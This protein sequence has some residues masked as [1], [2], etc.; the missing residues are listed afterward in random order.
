VLVVAG[1]K[2]PLLQTEVT[3]V[4]AYLLE[5]GNA[6]F[7]LD[8]FVRSGLEPVLLAYGVVLDETIVIDAVNHFWADVSSPTVTSYNRHQV[9]RD[10]PLTFYPGVRSLSP[11]SERV[12]GVAVTPLINS[13]THSYGETT[14]DRAQFDAGSD[15]PGPRTLMVLIN[16]RPGAAGDAVAMPS[17]RP[18][19]SAAARPGSLEGTPVIRTDRSRIAV[20]GDSDFATNSFFHLLGNGTLFLNTVHYLTAQE[21]LIGIEPRTDTLPRVNLTHRQI[22]GT[23]VLAVCLLPALLAMVGTAV[24]WRQR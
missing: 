8:P 23:F 24:W 15:L 18:D 1:P 12:L 21:N 17:G 20:V 2:V 9:T 7:M 19:D 6:F 10:L 22:K 5:G 13:S 14:P 4:Q 3:A 16:R 11:T